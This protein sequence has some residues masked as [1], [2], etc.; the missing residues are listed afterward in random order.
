[1]SIIF[2]NLLFEIEKS[3]LF[4]NEI[5]SKI[6]KTAVGWHL[7]HALKVF[8]TVSEKTINS[9]PK[10]YIARFNFKQW[11]LFKLGF[12]PRGKVRAP[13][14]VLPPEQI[15]EVDMQMQLQQAYANLKQLE[16]LPENIFIDHHIFGMLNK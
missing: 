8:N 14:M 11:F 10:K 7:D 13:K 2:T 12:F 1:M 3:F 5:N 6:S 4:K 9:N 15:L 16:L